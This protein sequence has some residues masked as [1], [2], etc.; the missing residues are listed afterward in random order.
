MSEP[1]TCLMF[2]ELL[3]LKSLK[4]RMPNITLI[5]ALMGYEFHSPFDEVQVT[6]RARKAVLFSFKMGI[7]K[8]FVF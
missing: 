8:V 5:A 7:A 3:V 2:G 1:S 6:G 4:L